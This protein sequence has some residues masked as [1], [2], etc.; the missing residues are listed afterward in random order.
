[1]HLSLFPKLT[2][3]DRRFFNCS[4]QS[5]FLILTLLMLQNSKN[6]RLLQKRCNQNKLSVSICVFGIT[7]T[8]T[9]KEREP[10]IHCFVGLVAEGFL[11]T[12]GAESEQIDPALQLNVRS[13]LCITFPQWQ[14]IL[15]NERRTVRENLH[16]F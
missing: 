11:H 6:Q 4:K 3:I 7:H 8:H 2:N 9:L 14:Y 5:L 12:Y 1:M 13:K 10:I 16:K 15:F